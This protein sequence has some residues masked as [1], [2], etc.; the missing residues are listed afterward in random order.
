MKTFVDRYRLEYRDTESE[1][2]GVFL[3]TVVNKLLDVDKQARLI[4]D[5]A[6]QYYDR[7]LTDIEA[8]KQRLTTEYENKAKMHYEKIEETERSAIIDSAKEIEEKYARLTAE[9]NEIFEKEHVNL[10][11]E[12]FARCVGDKL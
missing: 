2:G 4:L 3:N 7:V 12:L 10:E 5:E 8:E 1:S 11:N 6:Q 9:M